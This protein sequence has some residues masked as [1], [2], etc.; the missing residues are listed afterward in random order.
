MTSTTK[1]TTLNIN[2]SIYGTI[3]KLLLF[4]FINKRK[5]E[6]IIE[7]TIKEEL[8]SNTDTKLIIKDVLNVIT[9]IGENTL[10]K[11][12]I[13][14]DEINNSKTLQ[15]TINYCNLVLGYYK[16]QI[17]IETQLTFDILLLSMEMLEK[18]A[19]IGGKEERY[20]DKLKTINLI[21]NVLEDSTN[22]TKIITLIYDNIK[23]TIRNKKPIIE[24]RSCT[25]DN[26]PF[27]ADEIYKMEIEM[28]LKKAD[29]Q[30]L[31]EELENAYTKSIAEFK[32][33]NQS[34]STGKPCIGPCIASSRF[35]FKSKCMCK[36]QPYTS[37]GITY[38]YDNC[39]PSEC[40]SKNKYSM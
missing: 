13:T 36:I 28:K 2:W 27:I 5:L 39:H 34:S 30:I 12:N 35:G 29:E 11:L 9:S 19:G 15:I 3:G 7:T 24:I 17:L 16:K 22:K 6:K 14:L 31:E 4:I 37:Y 25:I 21:T 8:E 10:K 32:N 33:I 18:N 1:W 20:F 23:F 38:N 40:E 26:T